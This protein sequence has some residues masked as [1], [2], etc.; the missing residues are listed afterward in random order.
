MARTIRKS[1]Q[2]TSMHNKGDAF[3]IN[4]RPG[5]RVHEAR[6]DLWGHMKRRNRKNWSIQECPE[7]LTGSW[8]K[9]TWP[10][11]LDG[12]GQRTTKECPENVVKELRPDHWSNIGNCDNMRVTRELGRHCESNYGVWGKGKAR[13][14]RQRET[15]KTTWHSQC[16]E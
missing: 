7:V 2:G 14:L 15:H 13:H 6:V 12:I 4:T 9:R 5:G 8:A 1:G 16:Q 11:V 10:V 3:A